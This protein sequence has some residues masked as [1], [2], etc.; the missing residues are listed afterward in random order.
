ML[1]PVAFAV[2][3]ALQAPAQSGAQPADA[4]P[5]PSAEECLACHQEPGISKT[6]GDGT[7]K[8][9]QV[10]GSIVARSR[11]A[12][13]ASCVDCHPDA[14]EVPHPEKTFASVRQFTVAM[15]ETCQRCHFSD[16]RRTLDSAHA[17]A[18]KRGDLMAPVCVDCHGSHDVQRPNQPRTKVAETCSKCHEGVAKTYAGSVHG[19]DVAQ[20][21]GDVPTCTDCHRTH[22][23]GGPHQAGWKTS[24]PEICGRCHS[25]PERMKKYGLSTAVLK[26]YA[27]DFHGK[28]AALRKGSREDGQAFVALCTDCHG[29]HNIVRANDANSQVIQANLAT[30]CRKCH[31]NASN[32]FPQAWLSHY[33]PSWQ[34]SP[35]VYAVKLGYS[36]FIPFIIGGLIL[37]MLLHLWRMAVNR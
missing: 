5:P 10:D 15:S 14:R 17:A 8:P 37:Q 27:S 26:T 33:E 1:V 36:V 20:N 35:A 13:K 16:Y 3:L 25:D 22:D 30:T 12:G 24:T 2:V 6:F 21:I 28:T 31:A 19:K 18:V 4:A 11:H 32:N 34:H 9:L 29:V 23:I 7:S